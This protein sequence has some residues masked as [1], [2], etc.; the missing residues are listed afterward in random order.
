MR[1]EPIRVHD[2][3]NRI[4]SD[5][6]SNEVSRFSEVVETDKSSFLRFDNY[7]P[8]VFKSQL[9]KKALVQ[10]AA[11]DKHVVDGLNPFLKM[12]DGL[13]ENNNHTMARNKVVP[14]KVS[15]DMSSAKSTP[16]ELFSNN[17]GESDT[18]VD[19]PCWKATTTLNFNSHKKFNSFKSEW[20]I[21][22]IAEG[23]EA[24]SAGAKGVIL[25][26]QPEINGKTLL[27]EPHVLST[28][29]C[30][31]N[32]SRTRQHSL[33][34]IPSDIKFRHIWACIF[35]SIDIRTGTIWINCYFAFGND[36]PYGG[37]KMS[38]FGRDFGF[39]SLHNKPFK[40]LYDM[41]TLEYIVSKFICCAI[42]FCPASKSMENDII[43]SNIVLQDFVLHN[44]IATLLTKIGLLDQ[45]ALI[46]SCRNCKQ[47]VILL[48]LIAYL[49]LE[50]DTLNSQVGKSIQWCDFYDLEDKVGLDGVGIIIRGPK[51]MDLENIQHATAFLQWDKGNI[52]ILQTKPSLDF[53]QSDPGGSLLFIG[54]VNNEWKTLIRTRTRG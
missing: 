29:S 20:K 7:P 27:S 40:L 28:I 11:L 23:Q 34:I 54:G 37:Y 33:D 4:N 50:I 31:A 42:L 10:G 9:E 53:T 47:R 52:N 17:F 2:G 43:V 18:D 22:S 3:N 39:E 32:R 1:C 21:K 19:S 5:L 30:H 46:D 38:G 35:K 36:I 26:N 13:F 6:C 45:C 51:M 16:K 12:S 48:S 14:L 49:T 25:G 15:T 44:I 8:L 41:L 24:L